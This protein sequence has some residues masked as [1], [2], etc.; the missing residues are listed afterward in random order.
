MAEVA[1][2]KLDLRVRKTR[3]ALTGA[4]YDLMCEKSL[5][6]I[7]V[8]ELC[9]R[10]Q[11]RKATFYKHFGDKSELLTYMIREMQDRALE[12]NA[13]GLDPADPYSYYTGVFRYLLDFIVGNERFVT[14]VLRSRS[15]AAV[16]SILEG[17]IR[18]DIDAR[19]VAE[20]RED[21]REGHGMLSAVYAGAIV[22][23]GIWWVEQGEDR[24][25]KDEVCAQFEHYITRL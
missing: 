14:N 16:R 21:L 25:P 19:L 2:K 10:A 20:E 11:V 22:S 18:R 17:Q 9:D 7:T 15:N 5:D 13:V 8:T 23:A 6:Q 24:P 1:P 4:F 12:E 3:A